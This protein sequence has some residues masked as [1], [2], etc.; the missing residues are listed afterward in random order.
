MDT[1]AQPAFETPGG[2]LAWDHDRLDD[3][4]GDAA[5]AVAD[6]EHERAGELVRELRARLTRHIELEELVLF[7]VFE[8]RTGMTSGPT[9]VMR[10]E[11]VRI[12]EQLA[13]MD[14]ALARGALDG[15]R[16]AYDAL[17]ELL[18]AH[19]VKEER[20]LYPA[21]D[22]LLGPDERREMV[23]RMRSR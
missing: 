3:L 16:R 18:P 11:H 9:R 22:R 19:N 5:A 13:A 20:I 17:G 7:P 12:K 14:E 1:S 4:L 8:Q 23:E 15:F 6:D 21:I 10:L 2:Y